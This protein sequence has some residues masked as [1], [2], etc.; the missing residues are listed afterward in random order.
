M[1]HDHIPFQQIRVVSWDVDGTLFSFAHLA[2]QLFKRTVDSA[3]A[4]GWIKTG[5][6][7]RRFVQYYRLVERQR[8]KPDCMV[9]DSEFEALRETRIHEREAMEFALRRIEPR[10]DALQLLQYCTKNGITQVAL[11]DF[12]C[13]YKLAALGLTH[14]FQKAY[15]CREIGFWKPSPIPLMKIQKEFGIRP[16]QHLHIGD[17]LD[18][19]GEACARNGCRFLHTPGY[20]KKP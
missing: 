19:D 14:H 7:L 16:D 20:F 17:R 5:K 12:E 1:I 9:I 11:S 15:S 6:A 4:K 3:K 18:T 8:C 10:A 2:R 13:D